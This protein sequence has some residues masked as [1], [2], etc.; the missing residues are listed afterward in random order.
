VRSSLN[1]LLIRLSAPPACP[2]SPG[3]RSSSPSSASASLSSSA[4]GRS[5]R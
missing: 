4:S 5:P 3:A 2:R 1:G